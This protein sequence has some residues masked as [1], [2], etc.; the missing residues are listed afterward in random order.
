MFILSIDLVCI[1]PIH[2][3]EDSILEIQ[4]LKGRNMEKCSLS[5][6]VPL[7]EQSTQRHTNGLSH[8]Q[9]GRFHFRNSGSKGMKQGNMFSF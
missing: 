8:L 7:K 9:N 1:R 4:D 5:R 3:L 2:R 6:L